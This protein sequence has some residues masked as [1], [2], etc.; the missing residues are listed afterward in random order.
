MRGRFA[1]PAPAEDALAKR[2]ISQSRVARHAVAS[3]LAQWLD[4][5][6]AAALYLLALAAAFLESTPGIGVLVPGQT[7]IFVAGFVAGEGVL[8]PFIAAT[9]V[10]LGSFAGDA[11]G[12]ILGRRRWG[13]RHTVHLPER[14]RPG[15]RAQARLERLYAS[16]GG[17]AVIIARFQPV[18]RA[19]GPYFAG[20]G[21]MSAARFLAFDAIASVLAGAG[22]VGLG[23]LA[24]LGFE[25]LSRTLGFAVGAFFAVLLVVLVILVLRAKHQREAEQDD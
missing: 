14:M 1:P 11:V 24:G 12:F 20:L 16:H 25:H 18:G 9:L 19:F 8:D 17:K 7:V 15:P 13:T 21:G 23:Y 4:G 3:A 6:P 10:A 22:L 5:L 2:V